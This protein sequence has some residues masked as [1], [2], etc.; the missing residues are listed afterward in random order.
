MTLSAHS[1]K[2]DIAVLV[3]FASVVG[4]HT[5]VNKALLGLLLVVQIFGEH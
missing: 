5:I 3:S 4:L 2:V 1:L